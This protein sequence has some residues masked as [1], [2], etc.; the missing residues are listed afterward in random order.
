MT[1]KSLPRRTQAERTDEA[2]A[3]LVDA[4]VALIAER[5]LSGVTL[6][7]VGARAG[8]SRGLAVYHFGSKTGLILAVF[9]HVTDHG[10]RAIKRYMALQTKPGDKLLSLFDAVADT[11]TNYSALY[12]ATTAMLIDGAMSTDPA[13]KAR[14]NE[15]DAAALKVIKTLI[16]AAD[17]PES[18][19][20]AMA[21]RAMLN[22]LYGVQMRAFMLGDSLDV[23]AELNAVRAIAANLLRG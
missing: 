11:A 23:R 20:Q 5:G 19:D 3:A 7:D 15:A 2:R 14:T 21:A 10:G 4:A 8:Y 13:I 22:A 18:L 1:E 6:S 16:A 17:V 12:R 9:E